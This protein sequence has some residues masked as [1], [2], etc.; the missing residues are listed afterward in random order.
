MVRRSTETG[1]I[2][3][4]LVASGDE[5]GRRRA[6]AELARGR[7]L[8]GLVDAARYHR[9]VGFAYQAVKGVEGVDPETVRRLE[10]W[11]R[12]ALAVHLH[13]LGT[14]KRTRAALEPKGVPW[15]VVKGP[16]LTELAYR[17]PGLRLYQDLDLIIPRHAFAEGLEALEAAGFSLVDR[18][19]DLIRGQMIGEL[20]VA[21]PGGPE[22]DVHWDVRYDSEIRRAVGISTDDLVSRS[23][24]FEVGG[25]QARTFDP[26][27]TIIYLA[28]HACKQGGE[29]LIWLK[30]IE[31][32]TANDPPAWDVVVERALETRVNL[33]V[34]SMLLRSRQALGAEVPQDVLDRLLPRGPWR[35]LLGTLDRA[36]PPERSRGFGSPATL[37][38]RST[39]GEVGSTLAT[40]GRGL[41]HRA[42]RLVRERA[43]RRD[44]AQDD[45]DDSASRA[46][47]TGA[48]DSRD[49]YLEEILREP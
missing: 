24:P 22:L 23:R 27:D 28:M 47:P 29:R 21:S 36:F 4:A 33:L 15:V 3:R 5:E 40:A 39:R 8:P 49:R 7:P 31:R 25:I 35:G 20:V 16:A 30:D 10:R 38:V 44:T 43:L 48:P 37:V 32:S 17:K 34:G 12:Q 14:L 9:V 45:P 19:W 13:V 46:F 1:R 6:V 42:G 11:Y 2:L 26:E 41:V 18:N